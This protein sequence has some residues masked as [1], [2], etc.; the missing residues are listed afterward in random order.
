MKFPFRQARGRSWRPSSVSFLG[1]GHLP[2]QNPQGKA[3][4][5]GPVRIFQGRGGQ[6]A[7]LQQGDPTPAVDHPGQLHPGELGQE[8]DQLDA[9]KVAAG[10][11]K[12]AR[13][14]PIAG[15]RAGPPLPQQLL[16]QPQISLP[17]GQVPKQLV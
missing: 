1:E 6:R 5:E 10:N 12:Q 17:G 9:G 11:V 15:P 3:E 13:P 8:D 16:E 7:E 14:I 4:A 2:D